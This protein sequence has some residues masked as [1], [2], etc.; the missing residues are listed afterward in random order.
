LEA[1][2]R[3]YKHIE[4]N[5][6]MVY[7]LPQGFKKNTIKNLLN[8]KK[9][10]NITYSVHLPLW[11]IEPSSP[12]PFIRQGSANCLIDIVKKVE[13]LN[14]ET[15]VLHATGALAA[16]FSRL[17]IPTQYKKFIMN[18]FSEFGVN[19]I[20]DLINETNLD[21]SKLALE[22]IEFP[23]DN[24]LDQVKSIKGAKLC[25]DTGHV[26]AKYPG[27]INLLEIVENNLDITGEFHLHDG[28]SL[29]N[30]SEGKTIGDHLT[31]GEGQLPIEFLRFIYEKDFQGPIVFELSF[32]QAK[33]S[34]E[35]IKKQIP[36][37][38]IGISK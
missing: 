6:D 8:I 31:L 15:Y 26:L 5:L 37:I 14:P 28:F 33:K 9:T 17:K 24:T 32:E 1:V 34:I 35:F 12:N 21:P 16:E 25:I 3:G 36:E 10:R 38:E 4:L 11:S 19:T 30:K 22:T 13:D 2:N 23:F 20:K 18:R 7:F 29:P 27:D